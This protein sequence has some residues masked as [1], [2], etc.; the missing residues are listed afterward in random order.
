MEPLPDARGYDGQRDADMRLEILYGALS[1][2]LNHSMY[3]DEGTR[4]RIATALRGLAARRHDPAHRLSY[5]Q[6]QARATSLDG[7]N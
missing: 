5:P 1:G 3:D 6:R 4:R 2:G 7:V